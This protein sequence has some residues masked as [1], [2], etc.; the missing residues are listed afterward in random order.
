V[1]ADTIA[2][3]PAHGRRHGPPRQAFVALA[4]LLLLGAWWLYDNWQTL[5][6]TPLVASG[7]IEADE[8]A[9]AAEIAGQVLSVEAS[10]GQ[11]LTAGQKLATLDTTLLQ[12][13][14]G[15]AQAAVEV[16]RANAAVVEAGSRE[17]DVRQ[18]Q[19]ALQQ[20][21]AARDG[22]KV[23]WE[24]AKAVLASP[25]DLNAKVAVAR[26]Q[27][28]AAQARLAQLR[29]GATEQDHAAAQAALAV[30]QARREQVVKGLTPEQ[31]AVLEQQLKIAKNQEYLAQQNAQELSYRTD[32]GTSHSVQTPLFSKGIGDAQM[33]IAY[34]NTK[35]L[36]AQIASATAPPTAELLAQL[37]GAI[38]QAAAQ[39][40]KL[41]AG[42]TPEQLQA[43]AADVATAQANLDSLLE[44]QKGS[45]SLKVQVDAAYAQYQ[46]AEAAV[47][48]AQARLDAA[49][50]GATKP[51]LAVARAQ[52][53]QAE[54]ALGVLEAQL[55]KSVVKAP[56][57]GVVLTKLVNPGEQVAP[58][59]RLFQIANLDEVHLVVYLAETRY[60]TVALG[61]EV[62]ITVDSFPGRTFTGKVIQVADQ[63]EYTPRNV[64]SSRERANTVFAIKIA[65]PNA[66][67]ALKP[68]MPADARLVK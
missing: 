19:A 63:A 22:A 5:P 66:D 17:E 25:Q 15:Q 36:E 51:Q 47:A 35:L 1:S 68:G 61:Q 11:A 46:T 13:Q 30:A 28:A 64:Q 14:R 65:L 7:T 34:E 27:L 59:G 52:V 12:A 50:N 8:V 18:L 10:E 37:Q 62:A 9:L 2:P 26:P 55:A 40:A 38:D 29:A 58:G 49:K 23:A 44:M 16:A 54:A 48:A 53:S 31:L 20:A 32:T 6:G 42:A 41:E 57:A 56:T 33:G 21:T 24:N 67:H 4:V 43:A 3:P 39:V 60:G 45:Q